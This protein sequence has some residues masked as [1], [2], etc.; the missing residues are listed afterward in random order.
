MQFD[1]FYKTHKKNKY[2][3]RIAK[4]GMLEVYLWFRSESFMN[5]KGGKPAPNEIMT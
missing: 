5:K 3:K 1:K 4:D 2:D